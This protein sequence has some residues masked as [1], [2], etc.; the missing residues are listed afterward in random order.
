MEGDFRAVEN[1]Q[2]FILAVQEPG[3]QSI[4][5]DEVGFAREEPFE[6]SPELG[7]AL[8]AGIAL[9]KFEIAIE[10]PDQLACD[11]DRPSLVVVEADQLVHQPFRVD[12]T[13]GMVRAL[14]R[15][16]LK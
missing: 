7:G 8:A 4:E 5:G 1:T 10:P 14:S 15:S 6:P 3:K 16:V 9:V 2:E 12:P 11:V 13:E